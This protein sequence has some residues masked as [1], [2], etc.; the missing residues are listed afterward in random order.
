M[1]LIEFDFFC[2][3]CADFLSLIPQGR[4]SPSVESVDSSGEEEYDCYTCMLSHSS[5][6][7]TELDL[8]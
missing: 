3:I 5:A 8:I 6:I 2:M 7:S 4:K 1:S